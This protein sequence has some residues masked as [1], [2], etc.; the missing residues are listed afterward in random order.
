MNT[1]SPAP[2]RALSAPVV[3]TEHRTVHGY[4][5]VFRT[6]GD[7]DQVLLLV[8]GIGDNSDTWSELLPRLAERYTV[9]APDLLGHGR[10]DKPRADYS[11]AAYANG[12][13]DLMDVLG[14]DRATLVG[15]SLGGGVA[16]QFAY[17]Y[18][19]RVER[20]VLVSTGGVTRDVNPILRLIS[21]PPVGHALTALQLP[22][23][24][25]AL[26]GLGRA[27]G[28][29]RGYPL[30]HDTDDLV[31]VLSSFSGPT[32]RAAFLRTLRAV[33]DWRG[34]VVTMLDR[35]YLTADI[36]TQIVW[37]DHDLVIP[38]RHAYL[39]HAAMPGSHLEIFC[40]AGHF[41]HHDDPER[42]LAVA[43]QFLRTPAAEYDPARR[44]QL[45]DEGV[46]TA[47]LTGP[48]ATRAAVID[49]IAAD[50]RSAT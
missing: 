34:Q 6:A 28:G 31:R 48:V 19:D 13:R 9:V 21:I 14:I 27:L 45:L 47:D 41:P 46:H 42:F 37:G 33:V 4:R 11:I 26:A 2:L 12:M 7:G 35:C 30:F 3:R 22:R 25:I 16:M 38:V 10:S 29:L 1:R 50:E 49:A 15:H 20:I 40:G 24:D 43:E 17:Q 36:P 5:R 32:A 39:A 8:H 44:R 23:A 18:P